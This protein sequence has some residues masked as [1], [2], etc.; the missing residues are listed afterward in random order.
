MVFTLGDIIMSYEKKKKSNKDFCLF[1]LVSVLFIFGAGSSTSGLLGDNEKI[2]NSD[3]TIN[4]RIF[5][6]VWRKYADINDDRVPSQ[7]KSWEAQQYHRAAEK[8]IK[9]KADL[10]RLRCIMGIHAK[11]RRDTREI[12]RLLVRNIKQNLLKSLMRL[13]YFTYT[14][15][16]G[17]AG[18]GSSYSNLFS[19]G[20][21]KSVKL[22]SAIKVVKHYTPKESHL[23]FS[24]KKVSSTLASYGLTG[25]LELVENFDDPNAIA[26]A[27]TQEFNKNYYPSAT[28]SKAEIK[29][30][31][32]QKKLM[33]MFDERLEESYKLSREW[34]K[35]AKAIETQLGNLKT[36][37][38]RWEMEEKKRLKDMFIQDCLKNKRKEINTNKPDNISGTWRWTATCGSSTFTG[39]FTIGAL[40]ETNRFKG[41]FSNGHH[42]TLEGTFTG[43]RL[44]FERKLPDGRTQT[45]DGDLLRD[46]K[47]HGWVTDQKHS[48]MK[49][50]TKCRFTATRG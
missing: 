30:L 50:P 13:T 25:A 31:A 44:K 27:M 6:R 21:S 17:A 10:Y 11:M 2:V 19:K 33:D 1:F 41:S 37:M 7:S 5:E 40:D 12:R 26:A 23:S 38:A 9:L 18:L 14:T 42:G 34:L 48:N 22:A 45:W 16:K 39:T 35:Q 43:N 29:L 20:I 46:R 32:N 49:L 24:D 47:I 28:L 3:C 15:I 4:E 36:E 8:Y